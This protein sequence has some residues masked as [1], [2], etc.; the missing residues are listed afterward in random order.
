MTTASSNTPASNGSNALF[1]AWGSELSGQLQAIG[2]TK[3]GDTGQINWSSVAVPTAANTAAGYEVYAFNDAL[4]SSAPIY[5]RIEYGMGAANGAGYPGIWV[6]LGSAT[7]GAG[8]ITGITYLA[9]TLLTPGGGVV[10][11]GTANYANFAC[12]NATYGAMW[13]AFKL[14][15]STSY[16]ANYAIFGVARTTNSSETPTGDGIAV[17][18]SQAGV[19]YQIPYSFLTTQAYAAHQQFCMVVGAVTSSLVGTNSQI[20]RHYTITPAVEYL[21]QFGSCVKAELSQGTT[22]TLALLGSTALTYLSLGT[23]GSGAAN[24]GTPAY[25]LMGLWQ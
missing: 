9:R 16:N 12:Y 3:T 21:C 20:Y 7:N 6:T 25:G 17:Y 14:G 10:S 23:Y 8:T 5:L 13:F 19:L 2:L 4:Q 18:T 22:A 15:A 11:P 1:Q 24:A